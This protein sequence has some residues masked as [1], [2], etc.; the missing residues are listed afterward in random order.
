[1][2]KRKNCGERFWEGKSS[3]TTEREEVREKSRRDWSIK[4]IER[5]SMT[6]SV[7]RTVCWLVSR[8]R[9]TIELSIAIAVIDDCRNNEVEVEEDEVVGVE[10]EDEEDGSRE[11]II[12][13]SRMR[14]G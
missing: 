6:R 11:M 1:M 9:I 13:E 4:V 12:S 5:D 8:I 7:C 10:E 2:D 14:L 3:H